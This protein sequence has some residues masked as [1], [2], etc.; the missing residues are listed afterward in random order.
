MEPGISGTGVLPAL[1]C[2]TKSKGWSSGKET[3]VSGFQAKIFLY[4]EC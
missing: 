1:C 3:Q 2:T 4:R